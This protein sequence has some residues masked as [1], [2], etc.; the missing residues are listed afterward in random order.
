MATKILVAYATV[1]GSTREVAE[2]VADTLREGALE[3]DLQ[4]AG[5]V[6]G[7][8]DYA[9]VVLGAPL[10]IGHWH[11]EARAFLAKHREA[12]AERPV[13]LFALGPTGVGGEADEWQ[14]AR[15]ALNA[16][17]AQHPWLRPLVV[18]VFGGKYDPA[19]LSLLHRLL[20]LLPASPLHNAPANDLRDREAI[21]SYACNLAPTLRA[22]AKG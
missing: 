11:K 16:D 12:L 13:A 15:E 18:E 2:A 17:L 20:G 10:Y 22:A 14:G 19:R 8:A 21:R 6:G 4:P 5:R 3:V 1:Y 7:L 9:A